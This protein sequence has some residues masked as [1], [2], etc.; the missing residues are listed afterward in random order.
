MSHDVTKHESKPKHYYV[1]GQLVAGAADEQDA[2]RIYEEAQNAGDPPASPAR[3]NPKSR[4]KA[5]K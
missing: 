5:K 2:I 4:R 1:N 3:G